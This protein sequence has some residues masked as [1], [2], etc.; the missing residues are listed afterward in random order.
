MKPGPSDSATNPTPGSV[1]V[2]AALIASQPLGI[3]ITNGNPNPAPAPGRGMALALLRQ[4]HP[5]YDAGYWARLRAFYK[6]GRKLLRDPAI[7]KEVFPQHRDEI[8]EVYKERCARAFYVPYAGEIVDHIIASLTSEPLVVSLNDDK[9]KPKKPGAASP[10]EPLPE[11]YDAFT[12]DCSAEGGAETNINQLVRATILEALQVRCAWVQYD[13]ARAI[14]AEGNPKVY[15]SKA[16]QEKDASLDVYAFNVPAESVIDWEDA[17]TSGELEWVMTHFVEAKRAGI[18]S[19]RSV[20]T[21]RWTFWTEETWDEYAITYDRRKPPEADK[22]VPWVDG[23]THTHG[24]VPFRR[25]EV[26]DGLWVMEKLEGLAREHFNKRSGLA[27]AELQSLL[28]ELYEFLGPEVGAPGAMVGENQE[29]VDRSVNQKRGQGFVQT[30]G[31]ED[32]AEFVGPDSAPFDH[33][34]TSCRDVRDEMHR[35]THQMKLA[36]DNTAA[37]LTR[38]GESKAQDKASEQVVLTY[39]GLLCREFLKGLM[40]DVARARREVQLVDRW[41]VKGMEKFDEVATGDTIDNAV[42]LEG[43]DIP[44]PTFKRLHAMQ[45][46]RVVLGDNATPEDYE[47]IEEELESNITDDQFDPAAEA[48]AATQDAEAQRQHELALKATVPGGKP[49]GG[50]PPAK[51]PPAPNGKAA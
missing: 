14:D 40:Q 43:V 46:A 5:E 27:W 47:A 21:E 50:A 30:L 37:A 17:A 48:D 3:D 33:A 9:T 11:F 34:L 15:T 6:G 26:P 10:P 49:G 31:A 13:T 45:V 39:L 29:D 12:K 22:I 35:V 8:S 19:S 7:M 28:P 36:V 1:Y 44:S 25:L 16:E 32:K 51:A 23:G 20:V 2:E 41:K 38:S 42:A 18:A 4:T 24:K